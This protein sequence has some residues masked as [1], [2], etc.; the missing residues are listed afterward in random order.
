MQK[1]VVQSWKWGLLAAVLSLAAAVA[2]PGTAR[3]EDVQEPGISQ[4][5]V[6]TSDAKLLRAPWVGAG[7]DDTVLQSGVVEEDDEVTYTYDVL[8]E[9]GDG[10]GDAAAISAIGLPGSVMDST[11]ITP[12]QL[13]GL[14][15]K[16]IYVG[17]QSAPSSGTDGTTGANTDSGTDGGAGTDGTASSA[18]TGNI[19]G[20]DNVALK[21]V[22]V[23]QPV[24]VIG[25]KAFAGVDFE[26]VVILPD[27]LRELGAGAF[28][29]ASFRYDFTMGNGLTEI[30]GGAL[31]GATFH[32]GV[33]L[34][35]KLQ[36]IN[37]GAFR[38]AVF[39]QGVEIPATVDTLGQEAFAGAAFS[40]DFILPVTVTRIGEDAF[41]GAIFSGK[42]KAHKAA[43]GF[44]QN[45]RS[46]V[47]DE[48][49]VDLC[50]DDAGV[51]HMADG[52]CEV[53]GY[54][55][56]PDSSGEAG[57][58]CTVTFDS[59]GGPAVEDQVIDTRDD[60]SH[61]AVMPDTPVREGYIF[62]GWYLG[63]EYYLFNTPVT[64]DITLVAHWVREDTKDT[65][66]MG[67]GAGDSGTGTEDPGQGSG[68]AGTE[69]PGQGSGDDSVTGDDQGDSGKGEDKGNNTGAIDPAKVGI[70]LSG[71][72]FASSY[73]SDDK[74]FGGQMFFGFVGKH[75]DGSLRLCV[76][77][78]GIT[79]EEAALLQYSW[80]RA[81]DYEGL[82]ET[83][84]ELAISN[85]EINA[86]AD[87]KGQTR[88]TVT[89]RDA[90]GNALGTGIFTTAEEVGEE[91]GEPAGPGV[92]PGGEDEGDSDAGKPQGPGVPGGSGDG[93]DEPGVNGGGSGDAG[94]E[95]GING[96]G[97]GDSGTGTGDGS[98]DGSGDIKPGTPG[99]DGSAS[100]GGGSEQDK[101]EEPPQGG[102]DSG[103][104]D[105]GG[106]SGQT[107]ESRKTG[108]DG[109]P[110]QTDGAGKSDDGKTT[111]PSE[112]T[113]TD[114]KPGGISTD[115][116]LPSGA[117]GA[118]AP[119]DS[120]IPDASADIQDK[121]DG[122]DGTSA[123]DGEG[124]LDAEDSSDENSGL[125][126]D[127]ESDDSGM[128][129]AKL[130]DGEDRIG[131]QAPD[132]G[133]GWTRLTDF[134]KRTAPVTIPV[135]AGLFVLLFFL[136]RRRRNRKHDF[137]KGK[138]S[139]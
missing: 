4:D 70:Q 128:D 16:R 115:T 105:D 2:W 69:N 55:Y 100:H 54:V 81:N 104:A 44:V 120:Q 84:A 52:A 18:G 49:F 60:S 107:D 31:E 42:V 20:R 37:G 19:F 121:P 68:D 94:T 79:D 78:T 46:Y 48:S 56:V 129:V 61:V 36:A 33:H 101:E 64:E 137:L 66:G 22:I 91:T 130:P 110:G 11:L 12:D 10:T 45:L 29:G 7:A 75:Y 87:E 89:V 26:G 14:P 109:Q 92:S 95:T 97:S 126:D 131:T 67:D 111:N 1:K 76:T 139:I 41:K 34:P 35:E 106:K 90:A 136:L 57:R 17:T 125:T 99:A 134:V 127:A 27:S 80:I 32:L 9:D 50:T 65:S 86:H 40:Q 122:S 63:T 30:S 21:T 62:H 116:S 138:G 58:Y 72:G 5:E 85:E 15:V 103:K 102:E 51:D 83:G 132:S 28:A 53:C 118:G 38:R 88:Y 135:A 82:A 73:T 8:D 117:G 47:A 23:S 123:G 108:E 77:V 133:S 6:Q 124:D 74:L 13:G 119:A 24:E 93:S 43:D 3:A 113:G 96:G 98:G 112:Q 25:D 59:A 71:T 114:K 39:E